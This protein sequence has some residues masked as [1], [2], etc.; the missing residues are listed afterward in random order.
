M[1]YLSIHKMHALFLLITLLAFGACDKSFLEVVPKGKLIVEKTYDYDKI[2]NSTI[3]TL[4]SIAPIYSVL[5]D[6]VVARDPLF[7]ARPAFDQRLFRFEDNIFEPAA[8]PTQITALTKILYMCNKI[9]NEVMDSDGGTDAVKREIL[10]EALTQRVWIYLHFTTLFTKPYN[11]AT[12]TTDL[13]FP[14]ITKAD[15]NATYDRPTLQETYDLMISDLKTAI[16]DLPTIVTSKHRASQ[17]VAQAFLG[18]VYLAMGKYSEALPYLDGA[19][20]NITSNTGVTT[21]LYDYNVD[22][23]VG[24]LL[25]S[26]T[27]ATSGP[28][29]PTL[30]N[31][32]ESIYGRQDV[33]SYNS[34][35]NSY[36]VLAPSVAALYSAAD[37]RRKYYSST[38]LTYPAGS[39]RRLWPLIQ[40]TGMNI[41]E[42]YLMRA[43]CRARVN[44]LYGTGSASEDLLYF[45]QRRM[46]VA[47][48]A[49]PTGL[50]QTQ[51]IQFVIDERLREFAFIGVRWFDMRRLSVDPLFKAN[52]YVHT[53]YFA[54]GTTQNYPCKTD[55]LT[56]KLPGRILSD[57]PGMQDNP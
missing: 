2:L 25:Y 13:G 34:S 21:K 57:N 38:S 36:F 17:A 56:L 18:K 14:L 51:M 44:S 29:L 33:N 6:E 19:I 23:L 15:I 52:T 4:F 27:M 8:E 40:A 54:D 12:A 16:P 22:F 20:A 24:G 49:V 1:K 53:L 11:P 30:P 7:G 5:G 37:L 9:I 39:M 35:A 45:R 10:A 31:N 42:I 3:F 26:S 47:S 41:P 55:R 48:A 28:A 50:T 32:I 43:E 46:P